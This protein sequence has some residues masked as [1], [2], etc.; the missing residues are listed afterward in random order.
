MKDYVKKERAKIRPKIIICYLIRI[1][2]IFNTVGIPRYKL[3]KTKLNIK[4][5]VQEDCV[6]NKIDDRF[7]IPYTS[8]SHHHN[9]SIITIFMSLCCIII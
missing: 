8:H 5:N 4:E 2:N 1:N 7:Y 3:K 9:Q 6:I